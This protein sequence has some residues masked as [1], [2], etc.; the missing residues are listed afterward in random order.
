MTALSPPHTK[1]TNI[2]PCTLNF[3]SEY[4]F[5][6]KIMIIKTFI[7]RAKLLSSPRTIFL[8]KLKIIEHP[9]E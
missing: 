1:I 3:Q 2:N 5:L 6:Y 9:Y 4:P 8:N 7:S